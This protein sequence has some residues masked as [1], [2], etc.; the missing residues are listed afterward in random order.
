MSATIPIAWTA[1]ED[2]LVAWVRAATGFGANDVRLVPQ[3]ESGAARGPAPKVQISLLSMVP[4]SRAGTRKIIQTVRQRYTVIA[5]GPGNVGVDFF[6]DTSLTPQQIVYV[7]GIGELPPSSA[8]GLLA[9]LANL[10]T[11]YAASADPQD[12][13]SVL[14]DGSDDEPLFDASPIDGALL[15]VAD[16]IPRVT[17]LRNILHRLVWRIAFRRTAT[18]GP[19][20]ATRSMQDCMLFREDALDPPLREIGF[21]NAGTPGAQPAI[22]A[23][24]V[25]TLALLD[26]AVR[27]RMTV[28][29]ARQVGRAIGFQTQLAAA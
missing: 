7:A 21:Y 11:G 15:S 29:F 2:A 16:A 5:N 12:T 23:D 18:N 20:E 22:T 1:M 17:D 3:R 13:A 27:G 24:R 6:P 19:A 9:E 28:A 25:E 26:I 14:V 4:Q 8:A 10:P